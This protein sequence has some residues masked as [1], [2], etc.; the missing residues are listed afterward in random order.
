MNKQESEKK[1]NAETI[2]TVMEALCALLKPDHTKFIDQLLDQIKA[3]PLNNHDIQEKMGILKE[4]KSSIKSGKINSNNAIC[5]SLTDAL[6]NCN[7]GEMLL[8]NIVVHTESI[9]MHAT[10][11]NW[12]EAVKEGNILLD[13]IGMINSMS[14]HELTPYEIIV[15]F[16]KSKDFSFVYR[17]IGIS[18][19][20]VGHYAEAE[21]S[22][23]KGILCDPEDA[24]LYIRLS[25][26]KSKGEKKD[27]DGAYK[28]AKKAIELS[29]DSASSECYAQMQ[30]VCI[31]K[32]A[33]DGSLSSDKFKAIIDE[34]KN[35]GKLGLKKEPNKLEIINNMG[36]VAEL[37]KNFDEALI[38]YTKANEIAPTNPLTI[39]N[40]ERA[41]QRLTITG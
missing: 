22:F 20:N 4:I 38:W 36:L 34:A 39:A 15:D 30:F 1:A 17:T 9:V 2:K 10:Q 8:A 19:L 41:Q 35:C 40:K 28:A 7:K 5:I 33:S 32:L 16:V 26:A 3:N 13:N 12:N 29:G 24:Y 21:Q 18:F 31:Y 37:E 6:T 23:L 27:L 11:N 14:F 25:I